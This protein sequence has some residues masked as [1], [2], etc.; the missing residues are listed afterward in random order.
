MRPVSVCSHRRDRATR[1]PSSCHT[2]VDRDSIA[3][4]IAPR[5]LSAINRRTST[6]ARNVRRRSISAVPNSYQ[7]EMNT[8]SETNLKNIANPSD[9]DRQFSFWKVWSPAFRRWRVKQST[10]CG[11]ADARPAK[12][13]DSIRVANNL[14]RQ[15]E[16]CWIGIPCDKAYIHFVFL[17]SAFRKI[18]RLLT[19]AHIHEVTKR[20]APASAFPKCGPT[21]VGICCAVIHVLKNQIAQIVVNTKPER[22]NAICTQPT[23]FPASHEPSPGRTNKFAVKHPQAVARSCGPQFRPAK[24]IFVSIDNRSYSHWQCDQDAHHAQQ[25]TGDEN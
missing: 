4:P 17:I 24:N 19:N 18:E 2:R 1:L 13:R 9:R 8:P 6:R 23:L 20:A 11:F 7:F 14:G 5:K 15:N 22:A 16:N 12:S 21:S 10:V 25:K 3:S